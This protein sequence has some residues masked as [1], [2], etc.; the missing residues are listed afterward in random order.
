MIL[1]AVLLATV[2]CNITAPFI[3]NISLQKHLLEGCQKKILTSLY[4]QKW[5][6]NPKS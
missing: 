5:D 6:D 4:L 3:I 1:K 2:F